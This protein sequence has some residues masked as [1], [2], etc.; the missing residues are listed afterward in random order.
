MTFRLTPAMAAA[1]RAGE[2][3]IVPLIE[4]VLPGYTMRHLV[5]DGEVKWNGNRFVGRD[6]K[7]GVLASAGSLQDGVVDEAPEWEL[8]FT[9]P[10][11]VAAAQLTAATTQGGDV[12]GWLAVV[13]RTTGQVIPEPIHLFAGELDVPRLR[14]GKGSLTVVWRC[15]SALEPF[16]DQEV[17]ARL[18]DSHHKAVWP[19]E[20][21]LA[22]MSGIEKTSYWGVEKPPSAITYGGGGGAGFG[23]RVAA[24]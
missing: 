11:E 23:G 6:P 19:G 4:V 1:L 22:N 9:P 8:S 2:S 10:S 12:N 16:H 20:T 17:A 14:V 18:S 3:P 15:V 21:G 24:L 13:D 7:F 5:G